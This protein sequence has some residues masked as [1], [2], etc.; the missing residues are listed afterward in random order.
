MGQVPPLEY[1]GLTFSISD[2]LKSPISTLHGWLEKGFDFLATTSLGLIV[3]HFGNDLVMEINDAFDGLPRLDAFAN[4]SLFSVPAIDLNV[5]HYPPW[6]LPIIVTLA[7]IALIIGVLALVVGGPWTTLS[8]IS[9]MATFSIIGSAAVFFLN[10]Y[11][12]LQS[13]GYTV[14]IEVGDG[15]IPL[16]ISVVLFFA[17]F[18]MFVLGGEQEAVQEVEERKERISRRVQVAN[19]GDSSDEG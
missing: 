15:I 13:F 5:I 14:S 12:Q 2:V 3:E 11:L 18:V 4:W 19:K 10:A 7:I 17:G 6:L 1:G 8:R 9:M 16:I